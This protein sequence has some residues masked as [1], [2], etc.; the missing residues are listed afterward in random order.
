MAKKT[1]KQI[2]S[3]SIELLKPMSVAE[4]VKFGKES[5]F[6]SRAGFASYKKALLSEVGINFDSLNAERREQ[7]AADLESSCNYCVTLYSDAKA[8]HSR[9]AVCDCQS[10]VLWYGRFF[11]DDRDFNGEQSS[12][13]MASA[14]KAVWLASKIAQAVGENSISLNL[15]VD[16]EWLTWANG[17]NPKVG[18]KAKALREQALRLNV[19]LTVIHIPG[20]SNPADRWTTASGFKKWSD[21]NLAALAEK[22]QKD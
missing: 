13:E 3:E 7:K 21:N 17:T 6:D 15:Y 1:A 22:I 9:F 5:G 8:S 20:E 12:G 18:G 4:L 14:K 16:A 11:E 2:V 10:E 19:A